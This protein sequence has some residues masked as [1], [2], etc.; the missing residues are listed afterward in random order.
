MC[1]LEAEIVG[2]EV[3]VGLASPVADFVLFLL[4]VSKLRGGW[5]DVGED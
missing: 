3:E 1:V 4:R 5:G 2:F